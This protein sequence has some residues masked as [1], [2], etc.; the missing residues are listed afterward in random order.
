MALQYNGC[1]V[2]MVSLGWRFRNPSNQERPA[3][4][5]V[6]G[7]I[8]WDFSAIVY[9]IRITISLVRPKPISVVKHCLLLF[10]GEDGRRPWLAVHHYGPIYSVPKRLHRKRCTFAMSPSTPFLLQ[11][12]YQQRHAYI[13]SFLF[14]EQAIT[15][16]ESHLQLA[17]LL[18]EHTVM[19]TYLERNCGANFQEDWFEIKCMHIIKGCGQII[20]NKQIT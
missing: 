19:G 1:G 2:R 7:C 8:I 20:K 11:P 4:S 5:L 13:Q 18:Q 17:R 9:A 15:G 6:N 12:P 14:C 3:E 16:N 10:H